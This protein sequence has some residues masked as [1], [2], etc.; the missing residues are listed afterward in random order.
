[1]PLRQRKKWFWQSDDPVK[2]EDEGEESEP[3]T[4]VSETEE[5]ATQRAKERLKK[6]RTANSPILT[7]RKLNSHVI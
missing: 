6:V 2:Q 5:I 1:M 4:P 3:G 7:I